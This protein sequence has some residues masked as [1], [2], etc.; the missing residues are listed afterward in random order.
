MEGWVKLHRKIVS[1]GWFDEPETLK[2]FLYM[3]VMANHKDTIYYGE[4]LKRGQFLTGRHS[5]CKEL[6][7]SEQTIRTILKRLEKTGEI[8]IKSTNQNSVITICKYDIYQGVE[9]GNQ[10]ATNQRPT[11]D[12]PTTNQQLTN[13]QPATNQRPTSDQPATN[14]IQECNNERMKECENEKKNILSAV[15]SETAEIKT[16]ASEPSKPKKKRRPPVKINYSEEFK[17]LW[18]DALVWNRS[19]DDKEKAYFLYKACLADGLTHGDVVYG[20][21]YLASIN[22]NREDKYKKAISNWLNIDSVRSVMNGHVTSPSAEKTDLQKSFD[23]IDA[24]YQN[25]PDDEFDGAEN[26]PIFKGLLSK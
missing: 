21:S 15:P 12:Q 9:E 22:Q 4:S 16:E 23:R 25:M 24:M 11:S 8:S 1:W 10:P 3:L 17:L 13:D 6:K 18:Q 20:L 26:Q 19:C 7:L 2:A 14:H 5:L